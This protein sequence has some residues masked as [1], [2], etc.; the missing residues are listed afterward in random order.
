MYRDGDGE[1]P[2]SLDRFACAPY[3][4][5]GYPGAGLSADE[6]QLTVLI[7][8]SPSPGTPRTAPTLS[9]TEVSLSPLSVIALPESCPGI[10]PTSKVPSEGTCFGRLLAGFWPA[11][12]ATYLLKELFGFQCSDRRDFL[13]TPPLTV[14]RKISVLHEGKT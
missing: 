3:F 11:V 5:S 14:S 12:T 1:P 2:P 7:G 8:L 10:F 4:F 6:R 13:F 9:A